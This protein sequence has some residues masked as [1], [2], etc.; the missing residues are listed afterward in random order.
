MEVNGDKKSMWVSSDI[1]SLLFHI[2]SKLVQALVIKYDE[3]FQAL[4]VGGDILLPKPFLDPTP[5]TIQP[6]QNPLGL[7][8][9]WKKQKPLLDLC[10]DSVIRWKL[11][12]SEM[13]FQFAKH[14]KV[15]GGFFGTIWWVG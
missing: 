14:V 10:F 4:P 7:L 12:A 6:Q 1:S 5:P 3:I 2:V 8:C 13:L 11:P 15:Q 9:V